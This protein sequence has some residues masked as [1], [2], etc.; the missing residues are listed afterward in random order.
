MARKKY[1]A[2]ASVDYLDENGKR[3]WATARQAGKSNGIFSAEYTETEEKRLVEAGAIRRATKEDAADDS[4]LDDDVADGPEPLKV[5][6]DADG[7]V[8]KRGDAVVS[9]EPFKTKG[10]ASS[11]AAANPDAQAEPDLLT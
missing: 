3:Q 11:W 10:E 5:A 1:V 4:L 9:P 6:K 7:Y 2:L 8:V